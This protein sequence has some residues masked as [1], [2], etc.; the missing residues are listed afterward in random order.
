[1]SKHE[2]LIVLG[3]FD[4]HLDKSVAKYSNHENSNTNGE[5]VDNIIQESN[6]FVANAYFQMKPTKLW[7][8]CGKKT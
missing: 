4:V 7:N 6:L 2:I 8:M 1:M 3:D 5:L